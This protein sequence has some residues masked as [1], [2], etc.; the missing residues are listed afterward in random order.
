M[1]SIQILIGASLIV[2]GAASCKKCTTCEV[3]DGSGNIVRPATETCGNKDQISDAKEIA[4]VDAILIGGTYTC[5][6]N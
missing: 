2:I 4:K 3:K 6:D 5:T 1:K